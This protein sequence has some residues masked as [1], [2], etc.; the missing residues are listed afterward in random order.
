MT[1]V[2]QKKSETPKIEELIGKLR[3]IQAG[4]KQNLADLTAETRRI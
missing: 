1:K 2:Q 3:E 4:L